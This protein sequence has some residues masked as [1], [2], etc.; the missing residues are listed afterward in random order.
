MSL[1]YINNKDSKIIK[2]FKL[3][4]LIPM[5]V[6]L[7]PIFVIWQGVKEVGNPFDSD[8]VDIVKS[9]FKKG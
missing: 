8:F 6:V 1:Y 5:T 7:Y 4:Y 3:L 9:L 2:I